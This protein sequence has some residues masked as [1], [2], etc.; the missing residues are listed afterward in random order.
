MPSGETFEMVADEVVAQK[1]VR[2]ATNRSV[3]RGGKTPSWY[4]G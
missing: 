2:F 4:R 3:R 1:I